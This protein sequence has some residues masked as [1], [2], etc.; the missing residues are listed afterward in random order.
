MAE[1]R[2]SLLRRLTIGVSGQAFARLILAG[3]TVVLVPLLIRAWGVDGYGQWLALTAL[4]SYMGL[5]NFGLVTTSA[6]EMVIASG[7]SD[8]VRAGHTY[9]VSVNLTIYIVLPIIAL[10]VLLLSIVPVSRGL[11]LTQIDASSAHL[12]IAFSGAALWFQTLRGLMVAALYATGSYGYAYYVQGIMKL[13]ELGGIAIIVSVFA[14]SQLS[15]A[16]V[17]TGVAL[18][19]LLIIALSARR[20]A[21]WARLDLR[22]FDR[23]WMSKQAKPAIG[24]MVSNLATQ[25]V[26]AQGPRIALGALL[27]GPA[28][29]VYAIYGTAIRFADQLLLMLVLPLEVEIAHS[30]GRNDLRRIER[31]IIVGT[32]ISWA[33]FLAVASAIMVCGPW[34]FRVWTTGRIEFSYS[35]MALYI[36]MSAA[37]LQGRVSLHALI[38]TNRLYGPSFVMLGVALSAVG[39]GA[40]LTVPIGVGG[41][42]IGGIVGEAVNSG[43]VLTAISTWLR[44]PL[45]TVFRDFLD[46]HSS[47]SELRERSIALLRRFRPGS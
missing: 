25:G 34:V 14:G 30:A 12:I 42:V 3:Y 19:E 37:N 1:G 22:V 5:S 18:L 2:P 35:L 11:N 32:H 16:M 33:L 45:C 29:A 28:V 38:S 23:T 27:G 39:L 4:T 24:F 41:M 6:N 7:A 9:Q 31:L 46:F 8:F 20:A 47:I 40:L 21:P 36:C 44:R 13:C 26:M 17:V 43:I 15:A 10:L